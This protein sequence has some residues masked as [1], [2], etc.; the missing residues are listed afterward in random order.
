MKKLVKRNKEQV[1]VVKTFFKS[2]GCGCNTTRQAASNVGS[3][4]V[5]RYN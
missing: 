3:S 5:A 1:N 4:Q 2:C